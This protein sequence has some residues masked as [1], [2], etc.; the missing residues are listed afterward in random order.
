MSSARQS[1]MHAKE[2]KLRVGIDTK[3]FV[4]G[5]DG[6]DGVRHTPISRPR[7]AASGLSGES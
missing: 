7:F 6:R 3:K 4:A 2:E 1:T 5:G